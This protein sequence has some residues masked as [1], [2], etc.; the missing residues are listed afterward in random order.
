MPFFFSQNVLIGPVQPVS[1]IAM[2]LLPF[3]EGILVIATSSVERVRKPAYKF[4]MPWVAILLFFIISFILQLE[5]CA[6]WTIGLPIFLL[7]SSAGGA[8]AG[9]FKL[10]KI[11][12]PGAKREDV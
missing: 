9:Y 11:D 3:L 12:R 10:K 2:G 1:I 7:L 4:F 8:V 5:D 6:C